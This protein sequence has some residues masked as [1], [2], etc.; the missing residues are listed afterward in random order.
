M[1][2]F[3]PCRRGQPAPT[4]VHETHARSPSASSK[5]WATTAIVVGSLAVIVLGA[6]GT[7]GFLHSSGIISSFPNSF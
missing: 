3:N 6:I 1:A 4:F 5:G 2:S 7:A